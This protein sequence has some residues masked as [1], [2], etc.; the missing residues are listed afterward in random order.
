VGVGLAVGVGDGVGPENGDSYAPISQALPWD[1]TTPRWSVAG[2]GQS[3]LPPSMAGLPTRS[4]CVR[5]VPGE[6]RESG[7]RFAG[8]PVTLPAVLPAMMHP[9]DRDFM[10]L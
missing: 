4:A 9:C 3:G 6:L 7:P 5:V 8:W 10:R 2:G 1:R